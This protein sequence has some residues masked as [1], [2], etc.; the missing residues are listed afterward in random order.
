MTSFKFPPPPPPP[1][2]AAANDN[3]PSY[4]IQ[5]GGRGRG[6]GDANRGQEFRGRGGAARDGHCQGHEGRGHTRARDS[7][8][9]HL[10]NQR[11]GFAGTHGQWQYPNTPAQPYTGNAPIV[12]QGPYSNP[13]FAATTPVDPS[14]LVQAMSFMAT[15]AGAQSMAAFANHMATAA[16]SSY[17]E[18]IPNQPAR[19]SPRYSPSQQVGQKRKREERKPPQ[20]GSKPPKVKA[21]VPPA[22]PT[23]GFSLPQP[24]SSQPSTASKANKGKDNRKSRVR[25]GLTDSVQPDE[26]SSEDDEVEADEEAALAAR[27]KGGGYAFEHDGEQISLQTARDIADWIKDRRRNFPTQQKALEKAHAAEVRR[28]KELEFVRKLKGKPPRQEIPQEQ[29]PP[30]VRITREK[31]ERK[32]QELAALRKKLHE[33]MM[34]KKTK[35]PAA[36]D[37]GLG[38]G[39]E[40]ESNE[41]DAEESSV[42]SESSVVSSSEEPSDDSDADSDDSDEA[43]E[44][45]SSKVGPPAVK[46]PPPVSIQTPRKPNKEKICKR[47]QQHGKCPF[48]HSC[49]FKHPAK[50]EKRIGLYEKLVEQELV[51][52]DQLA[53]EAIKYLGQH[54]FLG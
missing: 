4:Q 44:T 52:S 28:Q 50:E 40:T 1:P 48:G 14:A 47:W 33:S 7:R 8:G 35:A 10:N 2:K 19:Q 31:D 18:A 9:D 20:Q 17:N 38:Y 41:D 43:P 54:G 37:L 25:L 12:P 15:P 27:L 11:G 23:F 30:K 26:S 53:L 29:R 32:Q 49:K 22:I 3:Q 5:R 6:R 21:A 13:A 51:K 34:K 36:I 16:T 24:A 45:T 46:V 39:S 42:L